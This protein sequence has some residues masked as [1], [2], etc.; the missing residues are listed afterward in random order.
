MGLKDKEPRGTSHLHN[1]A[2]GLGDGS[3]PPSGG[4]RSVGVVIQDSVTACADVSQHNLRASPA[5]GWNPAVSRHRGV[6][7]VSFPLIL[8]NS[9]RNVKILLPLI[10]WALRG[11]KCIPPPQLYPHRLLCLH[12]EGYT[13]RYKT[14]DILWCSSSVS[15]KK[16]LEGN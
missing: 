2:G 5:R 10:G 1:S 8:S 3:P 4:F 15:L 6:T 9:Q 16:D 13:F 14:T 12:S 11:K 7:A